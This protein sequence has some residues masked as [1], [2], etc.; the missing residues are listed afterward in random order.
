MRESTRVTAGRG[1]RAFAD[2]FAAL[3]LPLHL[4]ALGY[5]TF[6]VGA[7]STLALTG[8][9]LTSLGVG[10][11]AHL[12]SIRTLLLGASLA[13]AATGLAFGF[14]QGFWVV[15]A[16]GFVGTLNV[17]GGDSSPFVPLEHA[18]LAADADG[19][20]RTMAFARYG[21]VGIFAGAFGALSIGLIDYLAISTETM[22]FV[23]AAI[24]LAIFALYRG[25]PDRKPEKGAA[26]VPLQQSRRHVLV[27]AALFAIDSFASGLI[28]Q[29]I[30]ALWLLVR[31]DFSAAETGAVFFA[32][33]LL[34]AFSQF[35]A[36]WLAKRIGLIRTMVFSHLPANFLLMAVPFAPDA[37]IA[38]GLLV[39]RSLLTQMDVPARQSYVMA[40]VSAAERPA[41]ASL[42]TAPR[43][44][45]TAVG[46]ILAGAMLA[47]SSFGWPLVAAGGIKIVYDLLLLR[48]F[49]KHK[50]PEEL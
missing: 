36:V 47:A 14:A 17:A 32:T 30:L 8:A 45:A 39:L 2:G 1:L 11:A 38:V 22:F 34:A 33:R 12:A 18:T 10:M 7:I 44:L 31:F 21:F 13:M 28:V 16:V 5:D 23:Y 50:P 49:A 15:A 29:A 6:A 46:P 48:L 42:T 19:H 27:L 35:A 24:G 9:A 43:T 4:T 41:A 37:E 25:V 20:A 40:T 26:R 3:L